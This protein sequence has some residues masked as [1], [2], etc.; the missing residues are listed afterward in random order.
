MKIV[1]PLSVQAARARHHQLSHNEAQSNA[2]LT[3]IAPS[4]EK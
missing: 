2:I 1:K 4:V 3:I